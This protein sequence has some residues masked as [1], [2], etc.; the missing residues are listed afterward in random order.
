MD[1]TLLT[2]YLLDETD[3]AESISVR[4]W[5]AAHPDNE[6]RY[7]QLQQIWERSKS[8]QGRLDMD[9]EEAWGRFVQRR[10]AAPRLRPNTSI[11]RMGWLKYA[12]ALLLFPLAIWA[13]YDFWYIRNI[14]S[15]SMVYKTDAAAHTDTLADGSI[16]TLNS[17]ATLRYTQ[18]ARTKQRVATLDEGEVFFNVK[19]DLNRPFIVHSGQ[20]TVTVLGTS[21]HVRRDGEATEV[22]VESGRVKVAGL[23]KEVELS[24]GHKLSINTADNRFEAG[25][26]SDQLH[27]YYI[28]NRFVLHNTPLWRIAEVLSEAYHADIRIENPQIRDL[29]M[30]TTFERGDLDGILHVIGET[31]RIEVKREG[32]KIV[33]R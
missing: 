15:A 3:E 25:V 27:N 13:I 1:D 32:D 26:V 2:K 11:R 4:A 16:V 31:L 24:P 28:D 14:G 21:F 8:L 23:E 10:D 19:N 29:P 6:R 33:L 5:I 12:A 22:I 7:A 20:V 18:A 17:F 9:E 30:T